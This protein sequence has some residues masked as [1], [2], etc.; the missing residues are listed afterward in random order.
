MLL[1]DRKKAAE[2]IT[3]RR[4]GEEYVLIVSRNVTVN[5]EEKAPLSEQEWEALTALVMEQKLLDYRPE[6]REGR[7]FDFGSQV[8]HQG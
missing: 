3:A 5:L 7:V 4:E 8:C 2:Q 1:R 6:A